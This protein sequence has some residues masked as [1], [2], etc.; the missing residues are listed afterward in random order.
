MTEKY[1]I[2][3]S[4]PWHRQRLE[5]LLQPVDSWLWVS[6]P[7]ELHEA[8][9]RVQPRYVFFLH[10]HWMVPES[11]WSRHE[12][13]CFHMTDVPYGRGGS[14]L[15]NLI[16]AGKTDTMLTALRMVDA[17]DAG[18]VYAKR[19]MSLQGRAEDIY[20]RAG[21]LSFDIM[22]WMVEAK[23]EPVPQTG[24]VVA[25]QRRKPE[26]SELPTTGS[27][28]AIYDH[29]RMLDA[30]TYPL[31]FLDCGDFRI[32]FS[33]AELQGDVLHAKVVLHKRK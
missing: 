6:S 4:K 9:E 12:C 22:Q 21:Q 1:I 16:V 32:E 20:I 19:P 8:V 30:P 2:A 28:S 25:F 15:Q 5:A 13:V 27:L 24:E 23:P 33:S 31:A 10:W 7:E 3:S 26:Q 11:I 29:I 17:V 18:P 14:P